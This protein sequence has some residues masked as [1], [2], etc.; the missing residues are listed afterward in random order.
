M[1]RVVLMG[2][3]ELAPR[4]VATHRASIEAA[5]ADRVVVLDTP[6]GFQENVDVL[7]EKIVEFFSVSLQRP[8]DVASLRSVGAD[9]ATVERMLAA[10]RSGRYVF[11]GPGSPTYALGVWKQADLGDA[12]E[13]AV[14]AGGT[15]T[16][17]SAAALTIGAKTIPVYEIYKA[18]ADPFWE[19]GLD[20]MA[21]LGLPATVVPHW[22][23]AEGGN[24][25]TSRCFIGERRLS[26]LESELDHGIIGIDEHTAA[27]IDF[28][29]STLA[30][31]GL[32]TA[33]LRG[34]ETLTLE[35]GEKI[36]LDRARSVLLGDKLAVAEPSQPT[37]PTTTDLSA[38]LDAKDVDGALNAVLSIETMVGNGDLDRSQLR[39]AITQ[40]AEAARD[41]LTDER[42][43]VEPFV[44]GLLE[45]RATARAAG[46]FEDSDLIRDRLDSAGVEVRD[47]SAGV[48]WALKA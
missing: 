26:T 12:L 36:S 5:G 41:G 22:N 40:L 29:A 4:M 48:E 11:A 15:I 2:S 31:S 44:E 24:H 25:D 14:R 47:T 21:R 43:R 6:F 32:S 1:G 18:G 45:L 7:T 28:E 23:N 19:D 10:V 42:G 33:T 46:R 20:V 16:F 39:A 8:T 13:A 27:T 30:V 35:S 38:A 37:T 34:R 17:A 3:G 9:P